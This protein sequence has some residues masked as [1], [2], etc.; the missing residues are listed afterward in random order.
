MWQFQCFFYHC[1]YKYIIIIRLKCNFT[2]QSWLKASFIKIEFTGLHQLFDRFS[3]RWVSKLKIKGRN[4]I[5]IHL[6]IY[7]IL[8][9]RNK[10]HFFFS[11]IYLQF[12]IYNEK[13]VAFLV[14]EVYCLPRDS[15]LA[16][17]LYYIYYVLYIYTSK[18]TT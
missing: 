18:I 8:L 10:W 12:L 16:K 14:D 4:I 9:F 6:P 15:F 13:N 7:L 1:E 2:L 11:K 3:E 17:I 5:I